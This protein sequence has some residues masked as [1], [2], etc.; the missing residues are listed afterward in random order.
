MHVGMIIAQMEL[1]EAVLRHA[2]RPEQNLVERRVVPLR[3]GFQRIASEIVFGGTEARLDL[4]PGKVE[5]LSDNV[6]FVK[7][8]AV[9]LTEANRRWGWRNGIGGMGRRNEDQ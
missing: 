3:N 2:R 6:D 7:D 8:N 9:A 4:A 5:S 1:A